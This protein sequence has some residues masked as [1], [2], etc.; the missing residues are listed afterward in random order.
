M[1]THETNNSFPAGLRE[2]IRKINNINKQTIRILPVNQGSIVKMVIEY[3][4][5][6]QLNQ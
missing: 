1:A 4:F 5:N 3:Y 6:F 2:R